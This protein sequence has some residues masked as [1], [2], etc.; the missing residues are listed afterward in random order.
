[1]Q[2][3]MSDARDRIGGLGKGKT[4]PRPNVV[5]CLQERGAEEGEECEHDIEKS[6][7]SIPSPRTGKQCAVDK[8]TEGMGLQGAG[9]V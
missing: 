6:F 9:K 7:L 3:W 1:M 2:V 4:R 5:G 8:E